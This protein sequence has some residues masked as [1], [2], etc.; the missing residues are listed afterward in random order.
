MVKT[1][2]EWEKYGE[3]CKQKI[4]E[5][6]EYVIIYFDYLFLFFSGEIEVCQVIFRGRGITSR[7]VNLNILNLTVSSTENGVHDKNS[8]E[9]AYS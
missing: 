9:A 3:E 6:H 4:R 5:N 7:M 8:L 1:G 2:A